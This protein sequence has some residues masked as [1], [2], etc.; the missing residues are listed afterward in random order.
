M[1]TPPR[2]ANSPNRYAQVPLYR[3][4]ETWLHR[5]GTVGGHVRD[6]LIRASDDSFHGPFH[7]IDACMSYIRENGGGYL[8]FGTSATMIPDA[9]TGQI[10]MLHKIQGVGW[11][12]Y[13][14]C[15][16]SPRAYPNCGHQPSVD[17]H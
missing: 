5:V 4:G 1:A 13:R 11:W 12:D 15:E 2:I 7:G 16:Q 9:P 17:T 8:D 6:A 3:S 14:R 10:S